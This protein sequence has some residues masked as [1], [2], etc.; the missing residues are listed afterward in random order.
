M[1]KTYQSITINAAVD[2]VWR[3]VR[4]FHDMGWA[5][6]VIT[7]LKVIGDVPGDQAGAARLLNNAFHETLLS[8]VEEQ[9]TFSYSIDDGPSPVSKDDV[10]SY[11]GTVKVGQAPDANGTLV[12]WS[13][14][15]NKDNEDTFEFCH[16]IYVALLGDMKKSLE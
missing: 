5:P 13:S 1:G 15:W 11:V 10:E 12:E 16:G 8:V 4:N 7:E 3:A 2:V 6:N 14:S 9:R